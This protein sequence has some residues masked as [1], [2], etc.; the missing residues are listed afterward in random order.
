VATPK[1]LAA[2]PANDFVRRMIEIP[3][4]RAEKLAKAMQS[5]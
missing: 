5:A 2:H 3:R 4:H 1:D